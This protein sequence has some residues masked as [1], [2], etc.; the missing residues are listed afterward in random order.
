M[1]RTTKTSKKRA[2]VSKKSTKSSVSVATG[3]RNPRV[4]LFALMFAFI[5]VFALLKINAQRNLPARSSDIVAAFI[6]SRPTTINK[7]NPSKT[8]YESYSASYMVLADGSLICDTGNIE[9]T[10]TTGT[11]S[12][13]QLMKLHGE[14]KDLDL[15][16]LPNEISA[17][18][19][20][21]HISTFEGF[22]FAD[23]DSISAYSVF[24][25]GQ[26]PDK[27]AKMQ[28]KILKTC[29]IATKREERGKTKEFTIP[30][31]QKNAT[32]AD[33]SALQRIARA[34][35]PKATAAPAAGAGQVV[36]EYTQKHQRDAVAY[37]R[38]LSGLPQ[39]RRE[40]CLDIVAG[41]QAK[42][43]IDR[44]YLHHNTNLGGEV[45]FWCKDANKVSYRWTWLGENVG[46]GY[47]TESIF[48]AYWASPGHKANILSRTPNRI[49]TYAYKR[50]S[51]GMIFTVTV[52]AKW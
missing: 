5:G 41:Q 12:R 30:S 46:K 4:V 2:S 22:V 18:G 28:A 1:A 36:D 45:D 24:E 23:A 42:R 10:V 40:G 32:K 17:T 3:W 19:N 27:L 52:F 26:K 34:L 7:E 47:S 35:A 20:D 6:D 38:G 33:Q 8:V 31:S 48:N 43:M 29:D 50:T 21:T 25:D 15:G 37:V 13:G 49:G 51:D 16:T 39:L 9:G 44:N 11:L 14:L